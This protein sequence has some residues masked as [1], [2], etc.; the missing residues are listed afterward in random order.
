MNRGD[1]QGNCVR[2]SESE[3]SERIR[4]RERRATSPGFIPAHC[5]GGEI[6]FEHSVIKQVQKWTVDERT[7]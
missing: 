1:R 6:A 7:D 2:T 3:P 4:R 5:R